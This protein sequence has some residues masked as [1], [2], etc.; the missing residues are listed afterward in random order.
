MGIRIGF[1]GFLFWGMK[2]TLSNTEKEQSM[3][4]SNIW[5]VT[6]IASFLS[7]FPTQQKKKN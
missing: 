6:P 3:G 5:Y 4:A 1:E 7:F 2:D